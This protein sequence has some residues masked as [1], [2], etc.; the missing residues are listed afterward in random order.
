MVR[1]ALWGSR[2]SA[3]LGAPRR[4]Q[5]HVPTRRRFF[6]QAVSLDGHMRADEEGFVLALA[7]PALLRCVSTDGRPSPGTGCRESAKECK[8][9]L[10]PTLSAR[11]AEVVSRARPRNGSLA[12]APWFPGV[13]VWRSLPPS[14][15]RGRGTGPPMGTP[16]RP[17]RPPSA[18]RV[19][20]E[21]ACSWRGECGIFSGLVFSASSTSFFHAPHICAQADDIGPISAIHASTKSI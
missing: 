9:R 15:I 3:S 5:R 12:F 18:R 13:K 19:C 6:Q 1:R 7:S 14:R 21:K 11:S 8:R 16:S 17:S 10:S 2:V 20:R 4:R